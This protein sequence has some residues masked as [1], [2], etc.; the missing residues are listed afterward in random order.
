M[1]S[2]L[3]KEKLIQSLRDLPETFTMDELLDRI[4]LLQ[5]IE[6]GLAQSNAGETV[7]TQEAKEKF[8]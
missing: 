2:R 7:S 8:A 1:S 5:K 3:T 6:T 4:V